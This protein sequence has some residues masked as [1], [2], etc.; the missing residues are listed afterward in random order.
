[1][2]KRF[3][4]VKKKILATAAAP[5]MISKHISVLPMILFIQGENIF[6]LSNHKN[7]LD[8]HTPF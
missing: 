4:H 5:G 2:A 7:N 8:M 1:M 3:F 6:V